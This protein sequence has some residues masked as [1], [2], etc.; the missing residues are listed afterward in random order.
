M[1]FPTAPGYFRAFPSLRRG[2]DTRGGSKFEF[3]SRLFSHNFRVGLLAMVTGVL[4]GIPTALLMFYNGMVLGAFIAVHHAAGVQVEMWAWILPHGITELG[5]IAL[6]GGVGLRLGQAVVAPGWWTRGESLRIAGRDAAVVALGIGVML[7]AS[8][9]IES[10][11]R[12][13]NLGAA[14]RYGFAIGSLVFWILYFGNGFVLE[15]RASRQAGVEGNLPQ[16]GTAG[17]V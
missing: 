3:A 17:S 4:G 16:R 10:Y 7:I 9:I 2:R 15:R 12:Q 14:S 13:S 5:A 1:E 8:A 11:L 6:C